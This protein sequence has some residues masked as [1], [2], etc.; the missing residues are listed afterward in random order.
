MEIL[1]TAKGVVLN[2]NIKPGSN[3][4]KIK[5]DDDKLLVWCHEHPVKGKVNKELLNEFSKIFGQKV[6]LISGFTSKQ[7]KILINNIDSKKV[8]KILNSI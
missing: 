4:F 5:I 6:E 7:K 3:H 8:F 1:K 2:L